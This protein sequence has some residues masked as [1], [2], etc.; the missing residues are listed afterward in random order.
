[1]NENTSQDLTLEDLFV[2]YLSLID[3]TIGV[4]GNVL[5]KSALELYRLFKR[6]LLKNSRNTGLMKNELRRCMLKLDE[7]FKKHLPSTSV[8]QGLPS[9]SRKFK[10][11]EKLNKCTAGAV[12]TKQRNKKRSRITGKCSTKLT[13]NNFRMVHFITTDFTSTQDQWQ[14]VYTEK[15][16]PDKT[17]DVPSEKILKN[18]HQESTQFAIC[19][20]S[21]VFLQEPNVSSDSCQA[22]V[23]A[24]NELFND[25]TI[26]LGSATASER[27]SLVPSQ[28]LIASNC[29]KTREMTWYL[30]PEQ[31]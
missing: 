19:Q 17:L 9:V 18:L 28:N 13:N 24:K 31:H 22:K 4:E 21:Q 25:F 15:S 6:H 27:V 8:S 10:K 12:D 30:P 20:P 7:L 11:P 14:A 3:K 1:M 29:T 26:D 23:E 2:D 16:A 5:H